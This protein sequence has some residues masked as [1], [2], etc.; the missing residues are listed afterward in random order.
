MGA[1]RTIVATAV[2]VFTLTTV[3][4][5]GVQHFTKPSGQ[6]AVQTAQ[7]P[8]YAFALTDRQLEK[9]LAGHEQAAVRAAKHTPRHTKNHS[10]DHPRQ[11]NEHHAQA[12]RHTAIYHPP[13]QTAGSTSSGTHVRSHTGDSGGSHDG[14]HSGAGHDGSHSGGGHD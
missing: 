2:I 6:V 9:I 4:M 3:A 11:Q 8:T 1:L 10:A 13:Q 12:M 14:S 5:A 7:Q